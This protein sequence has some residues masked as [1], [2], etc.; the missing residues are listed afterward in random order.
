M[1]LDS[2]GYY[3]NKQF[4]RL[5]GIY[6]K[7]QRMARGISQRTLSERVKVNPSAIASIENGTRK[8]RQELL[9][10]LVDALSL[11]DSKIID[12]SKVTE[13][14]YLHELYGIPDAENAS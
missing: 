8:L 12:I 4:R 9:S 1:N 6:A 14:Q 3:D 5:F 11:E 2:L 13:A 10:A 7:E